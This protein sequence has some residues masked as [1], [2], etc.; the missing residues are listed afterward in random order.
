[1]SYLLPKILQEFA[2]QMAVYADVDKKLTKCMQK[3]KDLAEGVDVEE[4]EAARR[5]NEAQIRENFAEQRVLKHETLQKREQRVKEW[6]V[7][8]AGA[9]SSDCEIVAAEYDDVEE[10]SDEDIDNFEGSIGSD[11]E[12]TSEEEESDGRGVKTQHSKPLGGQ[13]NPASKR[14]TKKSSEKAD[15]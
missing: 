10:E 14:R 13:N 1:M 12:S 2:G 9:D 4:L 8:A 6:E 15:V 3:M 11:F 5:D 7:A